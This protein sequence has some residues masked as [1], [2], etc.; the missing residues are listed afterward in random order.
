MLSREWSCRRN[1]PTRQKEGRGRSVWSHACGPAAC[2]L[3]LSPICSHLTRRGRSPASP[4]G[5]LLALP[6]GQ[7]APDPA[8]L[9]LSPQLSSDL[10][11]ASSSLLTAPGISWP[12]SQPAPQP[13]LS[14]SSSVD[15]TNRNIRVM[16]NF[17]S[18]PSAGSSSGLSVLALAVLSTCIETYT[19]NF[20]SSFGPSLSLPLWHFLL[21]LSAEL[22]R[23]C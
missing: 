16:L 15:I 23:F 22:S 7:P 14:L 1:L 11:P 6:P 8:S 17:P 5:C 2:L 9:L 19:R 18:F 12:P 4:P 10:Q 3:L 21:S 13:C 20:S